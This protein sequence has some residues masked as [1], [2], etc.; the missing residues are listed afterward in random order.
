M[1]LEFS[2]KKVRFISFIILALALAVGSTLYLEVYA[3]S[4]AQLL[5]DDIQ[6]SR[7][8]LYYWVRFKLP[9]EALAA[10]TRSSGKEAQATSSAMVSAQS[11]PVLL[12]H[13]EGDSSETPPM[14]VFVEHMRALRDAGWHTITM[15]QFK[16]FMQGTGTVPD[17]SFLLTFDDG[18]TD[19]IYSAD[20]VLRDLGFTAVMFVV[21][22]FSLPGN[23]D[24]PIS[25]FYLS[26][27]QLAYML[28]SG[29]W[30]LESHGEEDHRTYNVPSASSTPGN[31]TFISGQHFLSNFFWLPD[32]GRMETPEEYVARIRNDL[33][34]SKK[35][36]EDTFDISVNAFAFPLND[37]GQNTANAPQAGDL[38]DRIVPSIYPFAF[39]QTWPGN[40]D[41]LNYPNPRAHLIKRIEPTASWSSEYLLATIGGGVAKSLPY[42]AFTFG[43]GWKSN[44]GKMEPGDKGLEL[45]ASQETTGAS[46]YL[47]GTEAWTNYKM[48]ASAN[49]EYGTFSLL[50]R[51]TGENTPYAVCAFS[52]NRIYLERHTGE[53]LQTVA[54]KPYAPPTLPSPANFTM[55]VQGDGAT[56]SA[57]GVSVSGSIAGVSRSGG[58]GA[59]VWT[60]STGSAKATLSRLMVTPL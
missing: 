50:A 39:Y 2:R 26:K 40:G 49:W 7:A 29:R 33:T 8:Q 6:R 16:S 42:T 15:K 27:S 13:G 56:C 60:P 4:T 47:D 44:W 3:R 10:V 37:L 35:K 55:S 12:Y 9:E 48:S 19:A 31:P 54:F 45:S 52:N 14:H 25:S 20:P 59:T 23:G 32:A 46:A 53:R 36:L 18:R 30:E 28:K 43:P 41:S 38:I 17:K 24:A 1:F 34:I 57:Y 22:G 5:T 21:T 11:V 51:Y 58:I